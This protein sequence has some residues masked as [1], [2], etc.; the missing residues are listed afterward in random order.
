MRSDGHTD[1]AS[2]SL[3]ESRLLLPGYD[4]LLYLRP[5]GSRYG[6]PI[7]SQWSPEEVAETVLSWLTHNSGHPKYNDVNLWYENFDPGAFDDSAEKRRERTQSREH[8]KAK[9][10]NSRLSVFVDLERRSDWPK[11]LGTSTLRIEPKPVM[12]VRGDVRAEIE[13]RINL[14]VELFETPE[15]IPTS[16]VFRANKKVRTFKEAGSTAIDNGTLGIYLDVPIGFLR[17]DSRHSKQYEVRL[18]AQRNMP[19]GD[20]RMLFHLKPFM[21]ISIKR[22]P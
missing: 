7:G 15:T 19:S 11:A 3:G 13:T 21:Q 4:L 17:D 6:S 9:W 1:L 10:K 14:S 12:A 5:D 8:A 22:L 20:S 16:F 2:K 18:P